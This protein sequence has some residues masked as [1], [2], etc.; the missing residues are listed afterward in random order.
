MTDD[1]DKNDN[2]DCGGKH[3]KL[4]AM[5]L[6]VVAMICGASILICHGMLSAHAD[7][8]VPRI[9]AVETNYARID[10]RL[11]AIQADTTDLKSDVRDLKVSVN[12]HGEK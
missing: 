11:K 8:C 4:A 3:L 9:R 1:D 7:D 2:V 6:G 5:I 10:E 12:G